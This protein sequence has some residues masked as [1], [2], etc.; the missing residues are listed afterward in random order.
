VQLTGA[1]IISE[2]TGEK[3][4]LQVEIA[5]GPQLAA[6]S[7]INAIPPK[8]LLQLW[9]TFA[10]PGISPT[11][12]IARWGSFRLYAE[13]AGIKFEKVFPLELVRSITQ[14]AFPEVGPHVTPKGLNK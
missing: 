2:I 1:Y 11:D 9:A 13:Y 3:K 5:P 4:V 6:I 12:F 7:D 8:A 10:S 14:L